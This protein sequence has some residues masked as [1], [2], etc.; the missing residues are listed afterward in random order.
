MTS[1]EAITAFV[2]LFVVID[3]IGLAP[4]FVALT[5]GMDARA[6]RAIALRS[7]GV[8]LGLLTLFGVAGEAVLGFLG[9][10]MPA[11]RIAGGILLFLTA[12]DMLFERRTKR[13]EDQA[14]TADEG[15]PED[16]S[17]FPLA[18]P[19]IAGPGAIA[20]MI[21]L[22]GEAQGN[23][24]H[25]ASVHG[26]ML[27]VLIC[28]LALFLLAGMLERLLGQVGINVITRLLGMLLAAL[29]VQFVLDGMIDLGVL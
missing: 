17:V 16:P 1:P 29:S 22:T 26:V 6:R 19:L 9:I 20:T 11:F 21:L 7:C 28:V 3:P 8:A 23:W 25:V 24:L 18:T 14:A 4:L 12:L 5:Q 27:V 10:S 2:A 15:H 13:R